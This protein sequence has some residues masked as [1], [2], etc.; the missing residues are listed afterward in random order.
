MLFALNQL[1]SQPQSWDD[2]REASNIGSRIDA[3]GVTDYLTN[4]VSSGL[5]WLDTDD[6]RE[7]IWNAASARLAERAGRTAVGALRR[8]F[9]ILTWPPASSRD[10][11]TTGKTNIVLHE[12]SLTNDNL[13]HKTWASAYV[14]ARKHQLIRTLH[15]EVL[16]SSA[17]TTYEILELGS[18]TGLVGITLAAMLGVPVMLTDLP[19]I[20][21]NLADNVTANSG[22]IAARGGR[23]RVAALDWRVPSSIKLVAAG[24]PQLPCRSLGSPLIIAADP[25]YDPEQ[26]AW[27]AQ[28]IG[29]H[30]A[31]KPEARAVVTIA[32]REAF[33]HERA[34]FAT[35]MGKQNL[36]MSDQQ[37]DSGF[38]D[39][40]GADSSERTA[41]Q[42]WTSVWAWADSTN[43]T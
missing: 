18:G 17:L 24:S 8:T 12:P 43:L 4:F 30:L 6:E 39:W 40:A 27:L 15:I 13:G 16:S 23:A 42:C 35:L 14:L 20:V 22:I 34:D 41:V 10:G 38:D 9:S 37:F 26:P 2:D 28:T 36:V 21:Q 3:H 31:A 5:V 1:K 25:I 29:Y 32:I 19:D 7:Q 11:T 33:G